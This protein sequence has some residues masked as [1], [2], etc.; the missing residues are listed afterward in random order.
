MNNLTD[1]VA[2]AAEAVED[3]IDH[4]PRYARPAARSFLEL[5]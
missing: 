4:L 2:E 1:P 3:A 5:I